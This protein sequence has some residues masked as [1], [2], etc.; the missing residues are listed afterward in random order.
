VNHVR[1]PDGEP[2]G[3]VILFPVVPRPDWP[4]LLD[5]APQVTDVKPAR[6]RAAH[7]RWVTRMWLMAAWLVAFDRMQL[8]FGRESFSALD[9][10]SLLIVVVMPITRLRGVLRLLSRE[11][12]ASSG[13]RDRED[14]LDV[15]K[16]A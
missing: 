11:R 5:A 16:S 8:A 13:E 15:S 4:P 14:A 3:K 2:R 7:V 12:R 10:L 9:A 1:K 6:R